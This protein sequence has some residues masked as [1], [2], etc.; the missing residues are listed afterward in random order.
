MY[1]ARTLDIVD[2]RTRVAEEKSRLLTDLDMRFDI[3][4]QK[5]GQP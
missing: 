1:W 5:M 3:I 4:R 2:Q